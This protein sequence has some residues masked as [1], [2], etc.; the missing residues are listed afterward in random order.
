[1]GVYLC[2][3]MI[4][5]NIFHAIMSFAG[6]HVTNW[7]KTESLVVVFWKKNDG[8]LLCYKISLPAEQSKFMMWRL[9]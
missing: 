2:K 6:W 1:M 8:G 7:W 3:D 9:R 4:M 5:V